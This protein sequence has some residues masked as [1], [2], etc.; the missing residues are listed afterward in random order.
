[1]SS[2][3]LRDN[4]TTILGFAAA[5]G[6]LVLIGPAAQAAPAPDQRPDSIT[7]PTIVRDFDERLEPGGHPDFESRPSGGFGVTI[8][9][10]ADRLDD[11]GN[12][13]FSG[14]GRRVLRPW[15]TRAGEPIRPVFFDQTAGDARGELG[16]IDDAGI[17]SAESFAT[18]FEDVPGVS[19]RLE[20]DLQLV[21]KPGSSHWIFDNRIDPNY[22]G[23]GGFFPI[24]NALLGNSKGED[25]NHHFTL[26]AHAEFTFDTQNPGRIEVRAADDAWVFI[27]GRLAIDLGGIHSPAKQSVELDRLHWLKDGQTYRI[28]FFFADRHRAQ[29]SLRIE[30][31]IQIRGIPA[32]PVFGDASDTNE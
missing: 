10:V 16:S 3:R 18:W 23:D 12:P 17:S 9:L 22:R 5:G 15:R 4:I 6:I 7:L 30:T 32:R 1:M 20:L 24:N 11:H 25:R 31:D 19:E 28:D 13:V 27:D 21:R 26:E 29:A 2:K 8:G 14:E